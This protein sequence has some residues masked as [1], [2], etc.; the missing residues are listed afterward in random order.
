MSSIFFSS[1]PVTSIEEP[2]EDFDGHVNAENFWELV[3]LEIISRG[4]V[5][6]EY[7]SYSD[8]HDRVGISSIFNIA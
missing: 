7:D 3:S 4:L 5:P 2:P 6:S 8:Y 1:S